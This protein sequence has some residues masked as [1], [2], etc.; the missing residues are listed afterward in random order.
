MPFR[1]PP[2]MN[3]EL[4]Q[5]IPSAP[6]RAGDSRTM[7]IGRLSRRTGVPVRA[8]RRYEEMGLIYTVGRS[9]GNYRLFGDEA[10]W[11][12][13]VITGLRQLG[14]TL[15]EIQELSGAY[16]C[17]NAEPFGPRLASLLQ[18]VRARTEQRIDELRHRLERIREFERARAAELSGEA[19]FRATDPRLGDRSGA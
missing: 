12:V 15:S 1:P 10:L 11:C 18:I 6:V 2:G 8:L 4:R 14:L 16:L 5:E 17:L 9:A 13:G 3:G 7:T 19:D